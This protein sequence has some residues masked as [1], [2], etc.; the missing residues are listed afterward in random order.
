MDLDGNTIYYDGSHGSPITLLFV[1]EGGYYYASSGTGI[2][3]AQLR[4]FKF[5]TAELLPLDEPAE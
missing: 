4:Q 3:V 5:E 2:S 1:N